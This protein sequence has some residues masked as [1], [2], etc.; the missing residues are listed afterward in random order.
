MIIHF[1]S[2]AAAVTLILN[3]LLTYYVLKEKLADGSMIEANRSEALN[4]VL[5]PDMN[6]H[7]SLDTEVLTT[8]IITEGD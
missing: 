7:A 6:P 3:L 4:F 1:L 5:S 8:E 2:V